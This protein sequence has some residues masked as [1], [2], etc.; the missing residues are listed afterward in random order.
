MK[1]MVF[2]PDTAR[3]S[4]L[5]QLPGYEIVPD[6]EEVKEYSGVV[7][8]VFPMGLTSVKTGG[9]S[10]TSVMLTPMVWLSVRFPS[11]ADTVKVQ[12]RPPVP[13]QGAAS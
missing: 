12:A 11:D 1:L 10:S 8:E 3:V 2:V 9:T 7:L 13:A 4:L 5:E 6:S